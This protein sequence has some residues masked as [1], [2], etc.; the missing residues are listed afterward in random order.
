MGKSNGTYLQLLESKFGAVKKSQKTKVEELPRMEILFL[1][2]VWFS[3]EYW[4]GLLG[5]ISSSVYAWI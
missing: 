1:Y 4:G 3:A 2:T 5:F